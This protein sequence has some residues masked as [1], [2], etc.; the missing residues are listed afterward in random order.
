MLPSQHFTLCC[1]ICPYIITLV[2]F[3]LVT[4]FNRDIYC[5]VNTNYLCYIVQPSKLTVIRTE[6]SCIS[7]LTLLASLRSKYFKNL[8]VEIFIII[9][10]LHSLLPHFSAA[11]PILIKSKRFLCLLHYMARILRRFEEQKAYLQKNSRKLRRMFKNEYRKLGDTIIVGGLQI[12]QIFIPYCMLKHRDT[13]LF[14]Q[15]T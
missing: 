14:V 6:E 2:G 4:I 12:G 11:C 3:V 5:L 8:Q 15:G 10:S 7:H 13:P 9:L 1:V